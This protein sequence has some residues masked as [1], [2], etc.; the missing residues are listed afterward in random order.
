MDKK[1]IKPL[2]RGKMGRQYQHS[3]VFMRQVVRTIIQENLSVREAS[4]RFGVS[5]KK[6][7]DWHSKFSSDIQVVD[8]IETMENIDQVTPEDQRKIKEL[9]KALAEANLKIVALETLIDVAEQELKTE[10]RKKSG[11]KQ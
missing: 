10:I 6:I 2:K 8:T 5:R 11:T 1:Q 7:C 3:L 9:E 4:A